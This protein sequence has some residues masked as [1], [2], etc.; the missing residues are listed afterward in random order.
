MSMNNPAS[1]GGAGLRFGSSDDGL[2]K[3]FVLDTNIVLHNP[4]AI[5]VFKEHHVVIPF[6]VIEEL[7]KMTALIKEN[8]KSLL[9]AIFKKFRRSHSPF[10]P[11]RIRYKKIYRF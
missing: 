10:I 3:T 11:V 7:D 6:M 9:Q 2:V 4:D 5:F 1:A 8:S